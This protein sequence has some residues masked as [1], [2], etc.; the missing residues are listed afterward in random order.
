[1]PEGHLHVSY[2]SMPDQSRFGFFFGLFHD[3][4]CYTE[5]ELQFRNTILGLRKASDLDP[6][7]LQ[8]NN[9]WFDEDDT[10]ALLNIN[11]NAWVLP[12]ES[13]PRTT[14][15][16]DDFHMPMLHSQRII[17]K[18]LSTLIQFQEQ[19]KGLLAGIEQF[20]KQSEL[21]LHLVHEA[22]E[23]AYHK[24]IQDKQRLR[25]YDG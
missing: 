3:E 18:P 4:S 11:Q 7:L 1:M 25:Y 24:K 2:R 16:R 14:I 17:W 23:H 10:V 9:R 19:M 8:T 15:S 22:N 6:E 5:E 20:I 21:R 12:A 13:K